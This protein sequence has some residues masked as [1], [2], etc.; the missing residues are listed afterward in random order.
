MSNA[1]TTKPAD[2]AAVDVKDATAAVAEAEN[3]KNTNV[4]EDKE[5]NRAVKTPTKKLS[6]YDEI[7]VVALIP[8]VSYKDSHTGDTYKWDRVGHVE[9]MSFEVIQNMW[10]SSKSYFRNMWLKPCDDRVI[11]KLGLSSMYDKY[12]FLMDASNY[13]SDNVDAICDDIVATPSALK[14]SVCN[15]IK[16]MVATGKLSDISVLKVLESRLKID[17]ISLI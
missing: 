3:K 8:N 15:K 7:D 6:K 17:L 4:G 10:R 2:N 1:S 5:P 14:L 13:T 16:S 9:I 12:D 11:K